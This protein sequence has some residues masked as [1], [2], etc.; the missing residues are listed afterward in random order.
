MSIEEKEAYNHNAHI[1]T[2]EI[3]EKVKRFSR[4]GFTQEEIADYFDI[5][6]KT[7]RKYYRVELDKTI[8]DA[9]EELASN[10][11]KDAVAGDKDAR[12]FWLM[13][14]GKWSFYKPVD[15]VDK[16]NSLLE[17]IIDKL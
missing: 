5:D 11:Y 14:K 12:K 2:D 3:R 6:S 1:P 15:Q 8:V 9:T 7:L 4:C 17:K 13:T 16:T 10:L